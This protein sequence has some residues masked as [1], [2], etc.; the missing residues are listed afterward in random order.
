MQRSE[1]DIR[2]RLEQAH[3]P[4]MPQILLKL[5]EQCQDEDAGMPELAALI[6]QDAGMASTILAVAN[7][8]AY[9]RSG[10]RKANLD[11]ALMA[12]GTDMIKT[13]VISESV[14]QMFNDFSKPGTLDL[15]G[16]WKHSLTAAVMARDIAVKMK[17]GH[18]EEAYLAGLLHDVGRLGLMAA[19][20]QEYAVNFYARDDAKLCWVEQRTLQITHA[21]AG[22]AIIERWQMDSFL[23]AA[24]QYHHEPA[25]R[26]ASAHPLIRIVMLAHLMSSADTDAETMAEAG[27]L[28]GLA[29]PDIEEIRGKA[30]TKV[31]RA[32]AALG[33]DLAGADDIAHQAAYVPPQPAPP[34]HPTQEKM[35]EEMRNMVLASN[36]S[37]FFAKQTDIA[38]L[39]ET[40]SGSARIL[41]GFTEAFL[42]LT[43]RSGQSLVGK[44]GSGQAERLAE[45]SVPLAAGGVIADA[46]LMRKIA[47]LRRDG[48]VLTLPEEQLL[49]LLRA[50]CL[51][52]LPMTVSGRCIGML[53][54]SIGDYQAAE[55]QRRDRFLLAYASQAAAALQVASSNLAEIDNRV[56]S[57]TDQYQAASRRVAHEVNNPLTI[58]KNYLGI[59][60]SRLRKQDIV[61]GEVA[62]LNEEI[63][64]VGQIV[65]GLTDLEPVADGPAEMGRVVREVVRLLRDTEYVPASV[66]IRVDLQ[67]EETVLESR[68]DLLKQVLLNLLKN[69]V[70]ALT[71]GG[72]IEIVDYGQVNRDG[73]LFAELRISDNGAGI[74]REILPKLFSP[75]TS[76]K[77][78]TGRGLGLSIVHSLVQKMG[79]AITC[80]S[81]SKGTSFDLL[82]PLAIHPSPPS[83]GQASQTGHRAL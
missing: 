17:H 12:I 4:T 13:L 59:L 53:V 54:G 33:I 1:I 67:E 73:R 57:V 26:V 83:Q 35:D 71:N 23:A 5:I 50:D 61:V 64:R 82:L 28:C 31:T 2:K 8:P 32:A 24:V 9:H 27:L 41:F 69:A 52:C 74:S 16:F 60:D 49:G 48:E 3:L 77:G 80:R 72:E 36:A 78:G 37:R 66:T 68:A 38:G 22:A 76:T 44:P 43:D 70:E 55:L 25:V 14:F 42:L 15:R 29:M 65:Q 6:S 62:I 40:I 81:S 75:V 34:R 47:F 21:E 63:D 56:A 20:P 10:G 46:A 58:I 19:A 39:M 18:I 7:S 51:I 11:Q 79:G 45:F 30:E